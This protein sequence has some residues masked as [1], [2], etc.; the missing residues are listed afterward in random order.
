MLASTVTVGTT[1]YL[2]VDMLRSYALG[3][4]PASDVLMSL[5]A[6]SI[7]STTGMVSV[8]PPGSTRLCACTKIYILFGMSGLRKACLACIQCSQLAFRCGF[9]KLLNLTWKCLAP[10]PMSLLYKLSCSTTILI[11]SNR[12]SS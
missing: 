5:I 11:T 4:A 2:L 9:E 6:D 10:G 1:T 12:L 8:L 7:N 3:P